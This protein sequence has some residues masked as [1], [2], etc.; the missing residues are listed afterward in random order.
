MHVWSVVM[1]RLLHT[2]IDK[3]PYTGL[4]TVHDIVCAVEPGK[5]PSGRKSLLS[6]NA[7]L[8]DVIW[9]QLH[10]P[11]LGSYDYFWRRSKW[12]L[13]F[14]GRQLDDNRT[15]TACLQVEY[16]WKG[17]KGW[18]EFLQRLAQNIVLML[19][20]YEVAYL[21]FLVRYIFHS[22]LAQRADT[23]T[24]IDTLRP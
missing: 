7:A 23:W 16:V 22:I 15:D 19:T 17:H 2:E 20:L 9:T 3:R 12:L 1:P 21:F 24:R 14:R 18:R 4:M 10:G 8:H 11:H 6:A 13:L 5:K